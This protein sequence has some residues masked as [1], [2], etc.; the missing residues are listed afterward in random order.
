MDEL[1]L[2][3]DWMQYEVDLS[4]YEGEEVYIAFH[5]ISYD[6]FIMQLDLFYVG[7]GE[8]DEETPTLGNATYN[9]Y[10]NGVL[11]GTT[12]DPNYTFNNLDN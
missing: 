5:Y 2:P 12:T 8:S 11:Q 1:E 3:A 7:P 10:L 9:V 6:K 4:K